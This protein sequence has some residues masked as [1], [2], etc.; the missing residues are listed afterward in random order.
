VNNIREVV[1]NAQ[2]GGFFEISYEAEALYR[3][4][5]NITSPRWTQDDIPRDCSTLAHVVKLL[6]SKA[7]TMYSTLKVVEIP[8]D[9]EWNIHEYD[10]LEWV[11]EAH[12]TWS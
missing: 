8:A 7:N 6:G 2:H 11:A 10:G 9:I 1:I 3:S 5:L 4:I 12:R